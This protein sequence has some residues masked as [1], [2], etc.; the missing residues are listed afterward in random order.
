[1]GKEKNFE[2]NKIWIKKYQ[3]ILYQV[4]IKIDV[5]KFSFKSLK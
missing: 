1:M 3:Y 4:T 5:D 2:V